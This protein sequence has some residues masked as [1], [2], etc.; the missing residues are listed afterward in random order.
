[1]PESPNLAWAKDLFVEVTYHLTPVRMAINN[2][3]LNNKCWRGCGERG[4][5]MHC[6]WEGRLVRPLWKAVLS[7]LKNFK[8]ELLYDPVIPLLGIYLKKRDTLIQKYMCTPMF[9]ACYL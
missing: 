1:M 9:I 4:S 7:Y 3:S 2:R 6:G 8:I 5:L